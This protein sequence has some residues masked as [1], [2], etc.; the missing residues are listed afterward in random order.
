M[1]DNGTTNPPAAPDLD[2]ILAMN[3]ANTIRLELHGVAEA[4]RGLGDN[5]LAALEKYVTD[6]QPKADATAPPGVADNMDYDLWLIE[7]V[8]IG[9]AAILSADRRR[10][11][12]QEL[13]D[14]R[15]SDVPRGRRG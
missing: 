7:A 3:G 10:A 1:A 4:L 8:K 9:R 5:A 11:A 12:R 6:N 2:A 13:R 14:G 15:S